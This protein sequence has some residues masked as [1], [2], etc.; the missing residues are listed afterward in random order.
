M[1]K[2][3]LI[4]P[5]FIFQLWFVCQT[6]IHIV[7]V[8]FFTFCNSVFLE[9]NIVC[10]ATVPPLNQ[11]APCG[12]YLLLEA[13]QWALSSDCGIWLLQVC[14]SLFSLSSS[15]PPQES[16]KV[17]KELGNYFLSSR[18]LSSLRLSHTQ[19]HMYTFC[20]GIEINS[21]LHNRGA[22]WWWVKHTGHPG[23]HTRHL[24]V[25]KLIF[26]LSVINQHRWCDKG[27]NQVRGQ[28]NECLWVSRHF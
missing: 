16:A 10:L 24:H 17:K 13:S 18:P 14:S 28:N 26:V 2:S 3:L 11:W 15:P 12:M 27:L 1:Y 25:E 4:L 23:K 5:C 19:T 21:N 6:S 9:F 22:L 20:L 7:F 8:I